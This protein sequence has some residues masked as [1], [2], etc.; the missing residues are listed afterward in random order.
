MAEAGFTGSGSQTPRGS[1]GTHSKKLHR[2]LPAF[3]IALLACSALSF[4]AASTAS[5]LPE[6]FF[7]FQFG[8]GWF[9]NEQ[10]PE[11]EPDMEAVARSGAKYWRLGFNC[12]DKNWT[13]YDTQVRLAWEHGLSIIAN[14]SAR[15][16][17]GSGQVPQPPEW[18]PQSSA[19]E[20]WLYE[21]VQHYGWNGSFWNGKSNIKPITVWEIWNE[22][23]RGVNGEDGRNSDAWYYGQFLKRS[24]TA[25]E[26]AQN[27]Q[28]SCC[29]IQVLM[30]G[31]LSIPTG[32]VKQNGVTYFN[33]SPGEFM[34]NAHVSGLGEKIAGVGIHPYAFET[35]AEQEAMPPPWPPL[36]VAR[37]EENINNARNVLT[38][39]YGA[40]EGLWI[41]E[42]GWPVEHG[43]AAHADVSLEGQR[44]LLIALFDWV[45]A[46]QAEKN[47]QSL[48]YYNY[49]DFTFD[50]SWI[51]ASGLRSRPPQTPYSQTTFRPAWYAFQ[52]ETGAAKW[53]VAPG[54]QTTE[55]AVLS[56]QATLYGTINP[57]GLPTGFHF[58]W[59]LTENYT[60]WV[61]AQDTEVGWKEGAVSLNQTLFGLKPDTVYHYRIVGIN[62]N[63]EITGGGDKWFK[64]LATPAVGTEAATEITLTGARLRGAVNPNGYSTT[65][66]IE[67]G[68]TTSYGTS[69][70]VPSQNI[71][72]GTEAVAVSQLVS[73]LKAGTLYHFRVVAT[74]SKGTTNG[75]DQTFTTWR[76]DNLGGPI[77]SDPDISS[78]GENRLDMFAKGT[79]N[80]LKQKYWNG[81]A[82]SGWQDLGGTLTSGPAAVSWGNGRIDVVARTTNNSL[83]H[84]WWES[85]TG[86]GTD[87]LGG[88]FT[89]DPDISSWGP[90][91]L[92]VFGRG[93]DNALWHK[94]WI[95]G[96]GWSAWEKLGGTLASGPGA[97][98]WA[99]NRID[100]VAKA[101]D[102]T[103]SHWY[104]NGSWH[105]DNLGGAIASDPDISSRGENRLDIYAKGTD[106]ALWHKY[107]YYGPVWSAWE[108]L[109]DSLASGPGTVSWGP[110][111]IDVVARLADNTVTHWYWLP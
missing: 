50:E 46:H 11:S 20:D 76:N 44:V 1:K 103:V 62:E 89:A 66:K 9:P 63:H 68:T 7:G 85:A 59:G 98:S 67:Y 102:N 86:W 33:E 61:P 29:G 92:D 22:P 47:I 5:A 34:K 52:E 15:C 90:G 31:L 2:R 101:S 36:A 49:R 93:T 80:T 79:G 70:P 96:S 13:K 88:E 8:A 104:Y 51:T 53:P 81:A 87:N 45:K 108:K 14:P 12:H 56:N 48:L 91:R 21:L 84:W 78:W 71:G 75:N 107:W 4:A 37:V 38:S 18:E 24:A 39:E 54:A 97:V 16:E 28:S 26:E 41:T 64:T 35:K 77:S 30:G 19:W 60:N 74:S 72:S 106:N 25:L 100:V 99:P 73:G 17:N 58:E 32:V 65:Y 43:D 105:T 110:N 27:A 82:W 55:A 111:R 40:G 83:Q 23:N 94:Y 6:N 95:N 109:G 3:L 10:Y 69:V 42:V 57:H